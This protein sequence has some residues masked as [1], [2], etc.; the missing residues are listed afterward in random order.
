MRYVKAFSLLD[1]TVQ[2][3][4]LILTVEDKDST[5]LQDVIPDIPKYTASH[6]NPR[7]PIRAPA[8]HIL[9]AL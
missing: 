4:A 5:F 7:R 1:G 2:T 6:P 9:V 8:Q 3:A